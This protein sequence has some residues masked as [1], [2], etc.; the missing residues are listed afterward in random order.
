MNL[1]EVKDGGLDRNEK[2]NVTVGVIHL[3]ASSGD[4]KPETI[5]GY[6]RPE[7]KQSIIRILN[8]EIAWEQPK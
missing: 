4:A 7:I 3:V 5:T 8:N 6:C 1:V 2:F